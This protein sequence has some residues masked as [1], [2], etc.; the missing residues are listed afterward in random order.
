MSRDLGPI[1][2]KGKSYRARA[3]RRQR[4]YRASIGVAHG[5]YGHVLAQEA[6]G[7]GRN[8]V[9]PEAFEAARARQNAGKGVAPRT[10]E[11]MLSS[12]AMAFNLFAPLGKRLELAAEVLRPFLPGLATVKAIEIEHTPPGDVFND[13]TGRGGVDCDLFV[14]GTNAEDEPVVLVIETKFVEPE[15]STCGFKK[16]GRA[17]KGRDVCPDDVPVGVNRTACLYA[18]NKGYAYWQRS[19]EHGLLIDTALADAGC[20]FADA[21]WQ[22]WVNL[23]LAHEEAKRRGAEDVHFVVCASP[24]N[25]I[26][27]KGGKVLDGFRSLLRHPE[28]VHLMDLDAL[29]ARIKENAPADLAAWARTLSARYRGI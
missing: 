19:D 2:T 27:L 9:L 5:R 8:F 6:A 24:N 17:E 12:Q 23:A 13:Q 29:L 3:E 26:L 4:E 21:K 7:A 22:L 25:D 11:N 20:P 16:S 14:E 18:R 15:F 28:A 10:F 1:Y